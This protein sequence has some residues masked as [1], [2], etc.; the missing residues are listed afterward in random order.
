MPT[1]ML[2][3]FLALAVTGCAKAKPPGDAAAF[4]LPRRDLTVTVEAEIPSI[5]ADAK[6]L[7]LWI[8]V[9]RDEEVQVLRQL[10]P[11]VPGG[12]SFVH[13][14]ENGNP[15]LKVV[16]PNPPVASS[17]RVT[18]T[19]SR[20]EQRAEGPGHPHAA[21]K[22]K[23]SLEDEDTRWLDD[24]GLTVITDEV[25][26]IAS[27]IFKPEMDDDT[28]ARA[29]Y[30]YV[31]STMKYSK[32][33]SGW[34]EGSTVWACDMRSGN[35]TDFHALFMAL[36]RTG[37][38]PARFRIGFNIPKA[39]EGPITGYHCWAEYRSKAR[40]AWIP[41]D[42]S[43]AWKAPEKRDYL[44]GNLDADR[45]GISLGR[46]VR[47]DGQQGKPLNYFVFPYAEVDGKP[48]KVTTKIAFEER[49]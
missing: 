27:E 41:V 13:D 47:F 24:D 45:V 7:V 46:D 18:W 6:E 43:E 10:A 42:I 38:I 34:G 39:T 5:A 35:C 14:I 26:K 25:R 32:E 29:A 15:A 44:F 1:R 48:V 17:A 33:G 19:I 21:T 3:L 30:D 16:V 9:P 28:K 20:V 49:S 37:G 23:K 4:K 22:P 8:P 12:Q 31:F 2:A 11:D 40:N 36:V